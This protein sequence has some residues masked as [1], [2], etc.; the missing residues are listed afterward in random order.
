MSKVIIKNSVNFDYFIV[1]L[2]C[3]LQIYSDTLVETNS[4]DE[5]KIKEKVEFQVEVIMTKCPER[6]PNGQL[7]PITFNI[8]AQGIGERVSVTVEGICECDCEKETQ[9][10]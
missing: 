1:I 5:I 7:K 10:V 2:F 6:L 3:I 8:S 4:C 9:Q